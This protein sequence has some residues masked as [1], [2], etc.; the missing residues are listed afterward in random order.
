[1]VFKDKGFGIPPPR[2]TLSTQLGTRLSSDEITYFDLLLVDYEDFLNISFCLNFQLLFLL[3]LYYVK[4]DVPLSRST[5]QKNVLA[6][7]G[8]ISVVCV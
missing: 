2:M 4:L 6:A 1:M 3:Y 5:V 8:C 7:L